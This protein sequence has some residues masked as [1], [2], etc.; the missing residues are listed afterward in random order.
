MLSIENTVV[1]VVDIQERLRPALYQSDDFVAHCVQ[2]LTGA[3]DLKLPIIVTEQYPKGLGKTLPEIQA[4]TTTASVFEKT[5]FSAWTE[6]V[7]AAVKQPENVILVGCETHICMLQTV[8]DLRQIGVNVYIPQECATSRTLAN[9]M[10]GLQQ[11]QAAGAIVSN[12]E[13]VLFQLL[14]D[15]KHPVFKPIS[16]L[17]Q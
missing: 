1:L 9:H 16:K 15:A 6:E 14:Q 13:S 11:I 17:I 7:Q 3:N 10:N 2:F 8:L 5:R 12:I 4:Q